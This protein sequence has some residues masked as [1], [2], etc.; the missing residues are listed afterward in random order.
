MDDGY[1]HIVTRGNN[2][3]LLFIDE[4]DYEMM[5]KTIARY[6]EK[7]NI[8]LVHY[9]LMPNHLH[10]VVQTWTARDLPKFMQGVL[11]VYAAYF[12]DKYSAVGYLFQNRYKSLFID[13]E[14]YLLECARYIE[15]NPLRAKLVNDL[16][17]YKYSSFHY[18]ALAQPDELLNKINP[19]YKDFGSNPVAR[20][21]AYLKYVLQE[22]PY[23]QIVDDVFRIR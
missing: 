19:L 22:R 5:K 17:E 20:Q 13:K 4:F 11:Q 14:S 6:L 2:K 15:R 1:Y 18:Y 16:R 3:K 23:D 8:G 21:A 12:K 7:F 10:W 9:C